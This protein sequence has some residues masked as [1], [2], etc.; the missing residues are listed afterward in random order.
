VCVCVC[1]CVCVE[2]V[3]VVW[4]TVLVPGCVPG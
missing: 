4:D 3:D 2:K 1:V